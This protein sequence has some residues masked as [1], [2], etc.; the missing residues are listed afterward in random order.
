MS[1]FDLFS[2]SIPRRWS[3]NSKIA[4]GRVLNMSKD[5]PKRAKTIPQT[6]GTKN[7]KSIFEVNFDDFPTSGGHVGLD[8]TFAD[9]DQNSGDGAGI[10][11]P[12]SKIRLGRS[13]NTS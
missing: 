7:R 5:R 2:V 3:S 6:I 10:W 11:G 12:N 4:L 8:R 9:L 1:K 13:L